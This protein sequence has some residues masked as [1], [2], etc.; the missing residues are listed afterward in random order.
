MKT[1]TRV[2]SILMNGLLVGRLEKTA[3]GGLTFAYE[4]R[5][6]KT[7]EAR[8]ISLSL[9]L[10]DQV[11]S[12]DV[13]YNFFDNLLPDNQQIRSRIQSK[14]QISTNQPFDL[15]A[16]IGR[17]CVGAIQILEGEIPD[18]KAEICCEPL[19][20]KQMAAI[21]RGY[22]N[23]PLG[24]MDSKTEFRISIAGAQE[25][26]AFLYHD[27]HW[28][29]PLQSTPTSHIFKLP[30]GYL[31]QQNMDLSD[32][33]ENEWLCSK[34]IEAFGL[35]VAP[36]EIL[37]FEE[38]KILSVERFDR[39]RS[40]DKTWIMRLPQEDMCQA[41]GV[42]PNLKY[43][44]EGG[45]GIREIMHLLLGSVDTIADRDLFYRSQVVFWLLAAIDGHAKNF[46]ILIE[47]AGKYRLTPLYDVMSAY[48]LLN[49][50]QLQVQKIKMAMALTGKNVHYHWHS[51][52][53]RYF[54]ETA[55]RVNYAVKRAEAILEETLEKVDIVIARV[56]QQLPRDF[57]K[58]IAQPIFDG[59]RNAK[60][61]LKLEKNT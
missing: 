28:N 22:Q 7:P 8:P 17:D 55:N 25:K 41:L 51:M 45:P 43:Q 34:I 30:I 32:S 46:S 58:N 2:L 10:V 6:L 37:H 33:C 48:P 11:F 61:K 27:G 50:G 40:A 3:Q 4:Q 49:K 57:P 44:A 31:Q 36:C 23:Y 24:M 16:S 39:K 53:L 54:L 26:A 56:S 35:P 52:Q 20:H 18:F 59:L 47:P 21:L 15:L 5:W 38:V 9:P 60:N 42:S 13:V 1:S 29:R 19:N 12:G 14:F